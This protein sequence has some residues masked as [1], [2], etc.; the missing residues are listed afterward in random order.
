MMIQNFALALVAVGLLA[1]PAFIIMQY[2][3]EVKKDKATDKKQSSTPKMAET[4]IVNKRHLA[5][6]LS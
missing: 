3:N 6:R 5:R 4:K 2:I 1:I